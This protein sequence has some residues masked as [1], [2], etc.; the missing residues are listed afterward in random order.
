MLR[1][2]YVFPVVERAWEAEQASVFQGLLSREYNVLV[3]SEM[4]GVIPLATVLSIVPN[5]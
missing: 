2:K 3:G 1:K 5:H 4:G